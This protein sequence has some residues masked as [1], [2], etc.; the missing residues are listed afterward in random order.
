[1]R[2]KLG[3]FVQLDPIGDS[4][5]RPGGAFAGRCGAD[6]V[7]LLWMLITEA[8]GTRRTK[9]PHVCRVGCGDS[10]FGLLCVVMTL[11]SAFK[12]SIINH[13][14]PLPGGRVARIVPEFRARTTPENDVTPF[15]QRNKEFFGGEV[16]Y[17]L[18]CCINVAVSD[19]HVKHVETYAALPAG[20][21]QYDKRG[22]PHGCKVR[23]G[24]DLCV[25][26]RTI[27]YGR[28]IF[29]SYRSPE[30]PPPNP[31]V[32]PLWAN[33]MIAERRGFTGLL[34]TASPR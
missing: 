3:L 29:R 28:K 11:A 34:A 25:G 33:G 8:P 26:S 10:G 6:R 9:P 31:R 12:S 17:L 23:A 19:R 21:P 1:M 4:P 5:S 16:F 22:F 24:N 14:V 27:R 20:I 7:C 15:V 30:V 13:R 18:N 2:G 32:S